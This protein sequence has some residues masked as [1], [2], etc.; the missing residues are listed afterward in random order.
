MSR[1]A[2]TDLLCMLSAPQLPV[3][4]PRSAPSQTLQTP[5]LLTPK[6]RL[7]AESPHSDPETP[8]ESSQM[9][10]QASN[11]HPPPPNCRRRGIHSAD[12]PSL[13]DARCIQTTI[14]RN[15]RVTRRPNELLSSKPSKAE[16]SKLTE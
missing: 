4:H 1:I 12:L 3:E 9:P 10:H 6:P 13:A 11:Y 16:A 5:K 14:Q 8:V 2:D 7:R 15:H